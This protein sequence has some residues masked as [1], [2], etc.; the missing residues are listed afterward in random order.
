MENEKRNQNHDYYDYHDNNDPL[1]NF[2]DD[3]YNY[4]K[5]FS[6]TT[7]DENISNFGGIPYMGEVDDYFA[8]NFGDFDYS[9][10]SR[11]RRERKRREEAEKQKNQSKSGS[12][13]SSPKLTSAQ[14]KTR[15]VIA[16]VFVFLSIIIISIIFSVKIMF[17]T[18]EIIVEA[19]GLPYSSQE[20]ISAS[21]I[22]PNKSIFSSKKKAV[23]KTLV[24]N[25]PYIEDADVEVKIPGTQII[26]IQVAIPSYQV[27]FSGG[28]AV[29]SENCRI[30]EINDVQKIN[31]P[32]LKGLKLKN[33]VVGEYITFEKESTKRVLDE[34]VKALS[35]SISNSSF[36]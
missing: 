11:E 25:Y 33:L 13:K 12:K 14:R 8:R 16:Y 35:A 26:K 9:E 30:L 10:P 3:K 7:L 36:I 22:D 1:A 15:R 2:S 28:Y 31:I 5:E 23:K 27:Q 34:V 4:T 32:L 24:E 17:K 29:I 18:K 6:S 19:D 20:I 21:G